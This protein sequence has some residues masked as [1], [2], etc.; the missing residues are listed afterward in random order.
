MSRRKLSRT[1]HNTTAAVI[2]LATARRGL[3]V[4]G[5]AVRVRL[6]VAGDEP[7]IADYLR[8]ATTTTAVDD[9]SFIPTACPSIVAALENGQQGFIAVLLRYCTSGPT[10]RL[11]RSH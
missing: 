1:R 8:Q 5:T 4:P 6:A 10:P 9:P 11:P 3:R 7:A 2:D